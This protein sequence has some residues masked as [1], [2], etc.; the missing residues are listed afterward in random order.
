MIATIRAVVAWY[1][2]LG[3]TWLSVNLFVLALAVVA[4]WRKVLWPA[5]ALR[6]AGARRVK[7]QAPRETA[8]PT[9]I[10]TRRP[11]RG[12]WGPIG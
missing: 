9:P 4:Y 12:P 3:L 5:R 2:W 11:G 10:E 8:G 7:V 1:W 6:K